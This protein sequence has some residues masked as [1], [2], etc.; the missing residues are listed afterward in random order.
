M[1]LRKKINNA[2]H[3]NI[4][5][6][7]EMS[8]HT[9]ENY[10]KGWSQ[11]GEKCYIETNNKNKKGTRYSLCMSVTNN[12]IIGYSLVKGSIKKDEF[13]NHINEIY[14]DKNNINKTLL[15]DNASTH[16]SKLVTEH[17]NN[18]KIKRIYGI[19]HYSRFNPIEFVFSLLRKEIQE[20]EN[21][22]EEQIKNIIDDF[23][24]KIKSTTLNNIFNHAFGLLN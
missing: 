6:T 23:I 19:P 1:Y 22:N 17:L 10:N 13:K 20:Y 21:Q 16:K 11:K 3:N 14:K 18:N 4:I 9:N 8:I 2:G 24:K 12:K 7:D 15:M 5:S